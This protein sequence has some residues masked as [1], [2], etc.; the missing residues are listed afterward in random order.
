MVW[1]PRVAR[2]HL[3]DVQRHAQLCLN[4]GA[5]DMELQIVKEV[6]IA[7]QEAGYKAIQE[8]YTPTMLRFAYDYE[9]PDDEKKLS[10]VYTMC[11]FGARNDPEDPPIYALSPPWRERA[12]KKRKASVYEDVD[13]GYNTP[14]QAEHFFFTLR[15]RQCLRDSRSDLSQVHISCKACT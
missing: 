12:Q 9:F 8:L 13:D 1:L 3:Q 5:F 14:D 4:I 2:V 10:P 7:N 11:P 15:A 6:R